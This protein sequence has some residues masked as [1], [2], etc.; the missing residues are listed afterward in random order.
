MKVI[1][2]DKHGVSVD[3]RPYA[4]GSTVDKEENETTKKSWIESGIAKVVDNIK[5]VKE[6]V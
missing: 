1:I 4:M 5:P 6:N 2:T 3:G